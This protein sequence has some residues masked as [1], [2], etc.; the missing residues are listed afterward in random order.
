MAV[1]VALPIPSPIPPPAHIPIEATNAEVKQST[2]IRQAR[3]SE[4]VIYAADVKYSPIIASLLIMVP[5]MFLLWG[6]IQGALGYTDAVGVVC[7]LC[8]SL[9]MA[10]LYSSIMPS[11][12]LVLANGQVRVRNWFG[13]VLFRFQIIQAEEVPPSAMLEIFCKFTTAFSSHVRMIREKDS[14]NRE[15]LVSVKDP[16]ALVDAI[17]GVVAAQRMVDG[18]E[19][20]SSTQRSDETALAVWVA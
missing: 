19:D 10:T 11:K 12:Y 13:L 1:P 2:S 15:V 7:L 3:V 4:N 9:F 5:S 20:Q 18:S 14:W 17:Q 8:I 16:A 6:I